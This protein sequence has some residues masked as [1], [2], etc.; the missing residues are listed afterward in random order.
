MASASMLA[1]MSKV[2]KVSGSEAKNVSKAIFAVREVSQLDG[3][4]IARGM[5]CAVNLGEAI[6]AV[7]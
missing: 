2:L 4:S 3:S 1:K 7:L 6:S 5:A